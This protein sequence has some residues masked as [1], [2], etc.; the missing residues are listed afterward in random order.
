MAPV[1]VVTNQP[2]PPVAV[3]PTPDAPPGSV[4]ADLRARAAARQVGRTLD[5]PLDHDPWGGL[6]VVRYQPP[7]MEDV[8]RLIAAAAAETAAKSSSR[9][10]TDVIATCC[11]TIL[12]AAKDGTLHDLEVRFTG[13][14]LA[15]LELPL[16]PGIDNP[17]DAT[18]AEVLAVV[19]DDN[20]LAINVHAGKVM[21][22]LTQGGDPLGEGKGAS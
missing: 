16:P 9:A 21:T 12:G 11:Q 19:F 5:V 22:W 18:I 3:A 1:N 13:R 2:P 14:L 7:P 10:S 4:L 15:L 8:D 20:W 17:N 6:L